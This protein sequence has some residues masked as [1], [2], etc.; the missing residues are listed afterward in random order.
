MI[1]WRYPP[2]LAEIAST[3]NEMLLSHHMVENSS[4]DAERAWL[5]SELLESIRTTIFRQALFADFELQV[6]E[7]VEDG[8]P[9]TAEI[10]NGIYRSL[11]ES[12]YGPDYTID[13]DDEIEWAYIPHFYYKYYVF[14]YATGLTSGIALSEKIR[15]GEEGAIEAYLDMLKGGSSRPPV[16]MLRDAGVDLTKPD[17]IEAALAVFEKTLG[18]L[19]VLLRS[20]D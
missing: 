11:I 17:A 6:H 10:L 8:K 12:Y 7:L 16:D 18:Q 4:S 5:L 2:F 1:T 20:D 15:S 14:T 19:E 13:P 3:C 9:V